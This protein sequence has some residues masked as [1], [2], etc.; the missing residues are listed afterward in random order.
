MEHCNMIFSSCFT[1]S[2]LSLRPMY[3]LFL[4]ATLVL[5]VS[6]NCVAFASPL[7][8]P[9]SLDN[10]LRAG[11]MAGIGFGDVTTIS[12]PLAVQ[13]TMEHSYQLFSF[14]RHT[15]F[16]NIGTVYFA[17]DVP[18]FDFAA[19]AGTYLS[20]DGHYRFPIGLAYR[21]PIDGKTHVD[22]AG[23][24][25]AVLYE[26]GKFLQ[27][28]S[29]FAGYGY[30]YS[31]FFWECRFGANLLSSQR[32]PAPKYPGYFNTGFLEINFGVLF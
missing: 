29:F 24:S 7:T 31:S 23:S 18:F 15:P 20:P 13:L 17:S 8:G 19:D 27:R 14:L 12:Y 32:P 16:V 21:V 5:S 11:F 4:M 28:L 3:R 6:V 26:T 30:L 25:H 9:D 22:A 2:K 10:K 1:V